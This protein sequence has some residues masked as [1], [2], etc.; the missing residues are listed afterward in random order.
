MRS[1]VM[2]RN[3]YAG[4]G[5]N[6]SEAHIT[7]SGFGD[8][9]L[10]EERSQATRGISQSTNDP[11]SVHQLPLPSSI[12]YDARLGNVWRNLGR[13]GR[14]AE[15]LREHL[16]SALRTRG[17]DPSAAQP[18]RIKDS[19]F[20]CFFIKILNSFLPIDKGNYGIHRLIQG[21]Q[22]SDLYLYR[23]DALQL[24]N[25]THQLLPRDAGGTDLI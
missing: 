7:P 14:P 6:L 19:Y 13:E 10:F 22:G 4:Q 8:T 5:A 24:E 18:F 21:L 23:G 1:V 20:V 15:F 3:A 17:S 11:L 2:P 9:G 16:E 12:Y 25:N